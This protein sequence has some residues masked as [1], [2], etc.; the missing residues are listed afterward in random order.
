[1][2]EDE[3]KE[4]IVTVINEICDTELLIF[5]NRYIHALINKME[6]A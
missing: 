5:I 3:I 1:M 4:E 2:E 6:Q